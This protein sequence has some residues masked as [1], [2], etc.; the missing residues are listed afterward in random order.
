MK[1]T[2]EPKSQAAKDA[3]LASGLGIDPEAVTKDRRGTTALAEDS[4]GLTNRENSAERVKWINCLRPI[5]ARTCPVNKMGSPL[6]SDID[7][8]MA[9]PEQ[10]QE[11]ILKYLK[12]I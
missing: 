2:E 1:T 11:A 9:T 8:L 12:L 6:V 7:L 10:R 3:L 5:V 4:A